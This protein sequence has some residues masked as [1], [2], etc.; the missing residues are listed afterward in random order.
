MISK[1][2]ETT[3]KELYTIGQVAKMCKVS[4]KALR[5]YEELG[6]FV[7]DKVC[8]ENGYR[9]YNKET[10]MFIPI[11]K[12]YKQMGFKLQEMEGVKDHS[13]YFYHENNFISKLNELELEEQAIK[14]KHTAVSDWFNLL[15]EGTMAIQNKIDHVSVKYL[16]QMSYYYQEQDFFFNYKE[17]IINIP[18]V[19]SLESHQCA[20]TGPVILEFSSYQDKMNQKSKK[21][22]ILQQPVGKLNFQMDVKDF[23]G[24]MFLCAY[25]IG[26]HQ[27]IYKQYQKI[28]DWATEHGY[29]C[30]PEAYER[31]VID[32]WTTKE[33]DK[34][35]TEVLIKATKSS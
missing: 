25:H 7:P 2:K 11:I 24:S 26:D 35:V 15:Q 22:C 8:E 23:G 6:I 30:G 9:Y 12:Y 14:N 28:E 3:G 34:F 29:T 32:Y 33:T 18:W 31:Y 10:M 21:S 17:S 5:F 27:D 16:D 13:S 1:E 19:N 4:K 20:I